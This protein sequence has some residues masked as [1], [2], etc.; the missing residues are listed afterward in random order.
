MRWDH[1]RKLQKGKRV[2]GTGTGSTTAPMNYTDQL[3][4]E[5]S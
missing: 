1:E 4:R 5:S 2:R 3:K